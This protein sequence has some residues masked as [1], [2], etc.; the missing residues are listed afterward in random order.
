MTLL[1]LQRVLALLPVL[2]GISLLAYGLGRLAPGDPAALLLEASGEPPDPEKVAQLRHAWGLD[3]P[4]WVSYGLWLGRIAQGDLGL[5]YRSARPVL[6]ELKERFP[7][8]LSLALPALGLA[9][10]VALPLGV[11]SAVR[12]RQALDHGVRVLALLGN[13]L[14]SFLLGYLLILLFA[15]QLH[16]LPVAG[17]SSWPSYIMPVLALAAGSTASLTRLVRAGVLEVLGEDYVRTARSKGLSDRA[18]FYKHAL[19]NALI[20]VITLAGIRL[21]HLMAGAAIIETVFSWPGL[22]RLIVEA[23]YGRD[24][25]VIQ[26]FVLLSGTLFVLVNLLVDL[27]Y[28]LLDPRVRLEGTR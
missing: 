6:Q 20:P 23:I 25:P 26:G 19:R 3:R 16:L 27:S 5:S 7:A 1:I 9:L 8:T 28:R 14:P 17:R 2:L 12:A 18:V 13:S 24:Y 10:L 15:V 4:V 21:A 22:G 11:L